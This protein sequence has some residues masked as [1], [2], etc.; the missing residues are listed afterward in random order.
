MTALRRNLCLALLCTLAAC[1]GHKATS[2][3]ILGA[4]SALP[5]PENASLVLLCSESL[6]AN[7]AQN[8]LLVCDATGQFVDCQY[9]AAGPHL[10]VRPHA[11]GFTETAAPYTIALAWPPVGPQLR[12]RSGHS[13]QGSWH[14]SFDVRKQAIIADELLLLTEHDAWPNPL[15]ANGSGAS[16]LR[17]ELNFSAAVDPRTLSSGIQ[18][19]DERRHES[20]D[21]VDFEVSRDQPQQ[22][23][24][25]PFTRSPWLLASGAWRIVVGPA[26]QSL[27]GASAR[28]AV[29]HFKIDGAPRLLQMSF[30]QRS[31]VS[32][33]AADGVQRDGVLRPRPLYH[34]V[35]PTAQ[36]GGLL[37]LGD[38]RG[39]TLFPR[40][41]HG[42]KAQILLPSDWMGTEHGELTAR[43]CLI[44][45]IDLLTDS[46]VPVDL[47]A[48]ELQLR[49][50]YLPR[51]AS[52]SGLTE[53]F[54][55]NCVA[56][57][58]RLLQLADSDGITQ[59]GS[60]S[61]RGA[62]RLIRLRLQEPFVHDMDN[63]DLVLT[64]E[65][66]GVWSQLAPLPERGLTILG[67]RPDENAVSKTAFVLG[68]RGAPMASL[69]STLQPHVW[70]HTLS[71]PSV[72]TR[73]HIIED[74][75]NPTFSR[76]PGRHGRA[77]AAEG[78]DFTVWFQSGKVRRNATGQALLD[79]T[80]AALVDPTGPYDLVPPRGKG[81]ALRA[82]IEYEPSS[83]LLR[84]APSIEY[85]LVA[86]RDA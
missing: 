38:A 45:E 9:S 7:V 27:D 73:W 34:P 47:C 42:S 50:G 70:L 28:P 14:L 71:F 20:L 85:I 24:L 56:T 36:S 17:I 59:L 49:L 6:D 33:A 82:R 81:D 53:R 68:T 8:A 13:A 83:R 10:L 11:G 43:R 19:I 66:D 61:E 29:R 65:H 48:A 30:N 21:A 67:M 15:H 23:F 86:Y 39:T 31:D 46:P 63:G 52:S 5:L 78:A 40:A 41:P 72:E 80:G 26:L 60:I 69:G 84:Y 62:D 2:F 54:E 25:R 22:V 55:S 57:S 64:L 1:S 79:E 58:L 77:E 44:T 32:A 18:V 75:G 76:E 16:A 51:A 4:A 35:L 74:C 12:N 37:P 3:R